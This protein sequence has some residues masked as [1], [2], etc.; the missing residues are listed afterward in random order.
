MHRT[1]AKMTQQT[2]NAGVPMDR[3]VY[4]AQQ[5]IARAEMLKG[6][7]EMLCMGIIREDMPSKPNPWQDMEPLT[8]NEQ[9]NGPKLLFWGMVLFA[10]IACVGIVKYF[11]PMIDAWRIF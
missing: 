8:Y 3:L 10:L 1:R 5:A 4:E 11:A 6:R 7:N 9:R 2:D